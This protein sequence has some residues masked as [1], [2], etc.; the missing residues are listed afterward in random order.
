MMA[1]L[2]GDWLQVKSMPL[3]QLSHFFSIIVSHKKITG[4]DCHQP[5][6]LFVVKHGVVIQALTGFLAASCVRG[7]DEE[8]GIDS[9]CVSFNHPQAIG[10]DEPDMTLES[11]DFPNP[12]F[13]RLCVPARPYAFAVLAMF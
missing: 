11:I 12:L 4:D 2:H 7:G 3:R 10:F 9:S 13:Q 6:Q 8:G 5:E 1:V